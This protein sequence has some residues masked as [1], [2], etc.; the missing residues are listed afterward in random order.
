V[1]GEVDESRRS[2]DLPVVDDFE[3]LADLVRD[4]P[5]LLLRY[6]KGPAADRA[7]G[8][9]RDYEADVDLPGL[10]VTTIGP[11]PWWT[12]P[13]EDWIA[14]RICKYAE[15]GDEHDRFPWL[16]EGRVVGRGPDH[17]PVVVDPEPVARI[18]PAALTEAQRR[19]HARFE[20]GEDS[21]GR[22][23]RDDG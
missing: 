8:P 9:S 2:G 3:A 22:I 12:R 17:E 23:S 10:S 19:Y 11:E 1:A 14:R 4:R 18:G 6:S 5:G 7:E 20:V 21:R 13:A 16:L 15:L